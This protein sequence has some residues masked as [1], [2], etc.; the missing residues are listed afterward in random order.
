MLF[1]FGILVLD[2]FL[3]VQEDAVVVQLVL[4]FGLV[5]LANE[6]KGSYLFGGENGCAN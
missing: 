1:D 2:L 5:D 3:V 6:V 4:D